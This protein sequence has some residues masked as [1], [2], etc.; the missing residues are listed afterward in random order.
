MIICTLYFI[1]NDRKE[2]DDMLLGNEDDNYGSDASTDDDIASN[3]QQMDDELKDS[4]LAHSFEYTRRIS[5]N[6]SEELDVD[7][8]LVTNTLL[9][10]AE[11]NG[12]SGP[13]SSILAS[14]GFTN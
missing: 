2:A 9:S 14:I 3:M 7:L 5:N 13:V 11:Q 10:Y 12:L 4:T 6:N 1:G 8:N